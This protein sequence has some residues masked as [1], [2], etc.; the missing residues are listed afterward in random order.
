MS[1]SYQGI[2]ASVKVNVVPKLTKLTVNESK[3]N[4][5]PSYVKTVVLTAAY[6]TGTTASVASS[7]TW[8]SSKPSVATVTDGKIVA[9]AK[10]SATIKAKF[11]GKTVSVRVTVK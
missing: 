2:N 10:G 4:L 11:N 9:V 1:G 6:D 5:A 8:T 3:L 7:A